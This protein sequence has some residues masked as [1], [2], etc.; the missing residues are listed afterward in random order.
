MAFSA[1]YFNISSI[2]IQ[3]YSQWQHMGMSSAK[4]LARANKTPKLV[5]G[6]S[7]TN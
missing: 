2:I 4:S 7:G 6:G 1:T 3:N 5:S